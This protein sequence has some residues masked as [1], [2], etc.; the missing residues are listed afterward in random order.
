MVYIE[1]FL[2]EYCPVSDY[3]PPPPPP[4]PSSTSSSR[5]HMLNVLLTPT[6]TCKYLVSN[7]LGSRLA[8]KG[9]N[10]E[11]FGFYKIVI[12]NIY[13]LV[14]INSCLYPSMAHMRGPQ[15]ITLAFVLAPFPKHNLLIVLGFCLIQLLI[16]VIF[17]DGRVVV[18]SHPSPR[19]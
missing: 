1:Q 12:Y 8:V 7:T 10:M 6:T 9:K 3:S 15:L 19:H 11:G 18:E 2:P 5:H 16:C 17:Q 14:M 13:Y 4:T